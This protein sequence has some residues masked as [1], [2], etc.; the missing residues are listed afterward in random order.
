[1]PTDIMQLVWQVNRQEHLVFRLH[2]GCD[3]KSLDT[4][5]DL[6]V[7]SQSLLCCCCLQVQL[8]EGDISFADFLSKAPAAHGN[9]LPHIADAYETCNI[10]FS[11]GTTGEARV[12]INVAILYGTIRCFTHQHGTNDGYGSTLR[13]VVLVGPESCMVHLHAIVCICWLH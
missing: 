1:M 2:L 6:Y 13:Y 3:D 8:R 9:Q 5:S 12:M 7:Q 10:L 11:S 4:G